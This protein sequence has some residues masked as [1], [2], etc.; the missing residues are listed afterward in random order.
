MSMKKK[1]IAKNVEEYIA[2]YPEDIQVKLKH[3]REIILEI[4]PEVEELISYHMPA[5]KY[6]G[7]LVYFGAYKNHIGF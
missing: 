6:L 3:I 4:V 7:R 2:N 1:G 5:Y